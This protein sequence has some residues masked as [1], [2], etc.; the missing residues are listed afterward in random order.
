M[1]NILVIHP[2]DAS[3]SVSKSAPNIFIQITGVNPDRKPIFK[4]LTDKEEDLKVRVERDKILFDM[5]FSL[6]ED[7]VK[8]IYGEG[9]EYIPVMNKKNAAALKQDIAITAAQQLDPKP[10]ELDGFIN[11]LTDK[12]QGMIDDRLIKIK[13][14]LAT[15][16]N[17]EDFQEKI[18]A[19]FISNTD[20]DELT[21]IMRQAL[22]AA[23]LAGMYD[24]SEGEA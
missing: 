16:K 8:E 18:L 19:N 3:A 22:A 10:T 17:F 24:V 15:A 11:Q 4:F 12:T 21:G 13:A 2:A 9:Y 7:K 6:T 20:P 14:L 23:E 5:G 1:N